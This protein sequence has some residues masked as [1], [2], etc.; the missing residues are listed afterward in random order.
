[1][2]YSINNT[3]IFLQKCRNCLWRITLNAI[4]CE[5]G[6]VNYTH[7]KNQIVGII[8]KMTKRNEKHRSYSI[9]GRIQYKYFLV[10]SKYSVYLSQKSQHDF[11]SVKE[12]YTHLSSPARALL[13]SLLGVIPSALKTIII[14]HC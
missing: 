9:L 10:Y 6:F 11:R 3:N 7:K 12:A 13:M 5:Q 2:W 8:Y 4:Y 14:K 1:M